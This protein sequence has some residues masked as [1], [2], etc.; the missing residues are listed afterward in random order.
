MVWAPEG[1][2]ERHVPLAVLT[3][4][5]GSGKTTLLNRLLSN[6]RLAD[7]AVIINEFGDIP[8]DHH[9]VASQSDEVIVLANGC[10]CCFTPNDLVEQSLGQIF[11]RRKNVDVP[12]FKR[13][14]IETS[15]LADPERLLRTLLDTQF[16]SRFLWLDTVVTTVDALFAF[17]QIER[18]VQVGRQ[19]RIADSLVITKSDIADRRKQSELRAMLSEINPTARQL[20]SIDGVVDIDALFS[21]T[22]FDELGD[23]SLVGS[24]VQRQRG[25]LTSYRNESAGHHTHEDHVDGVDSIALMTNTPLN[26]REFD[27][28]LTHVQREY[29]EKLLRIKG[30]VNVA[31][32]SRPV[33]VHG[34]QSVL[35]V[36]V[37][38]AEWPDSDRRSRIVLIFRDMPGEIFN[39]SW[40]A[41][42]GTR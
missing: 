18:H 37:A 34:V 15:G 16:L 40:E 28:W 3:G 24:W 6:P 39:E 2:F 21:A 32:E 26:W 30:I 33:V 11:R 17:Q 4:F 5:L 42:L 23:A 22:F 27:L 7:T 19:I 41:F 1:F 14:I 36:P 9:L 29:G 12:D 25:E 35:H 38:L 20:T 31:G 10:I 13:L 8:L